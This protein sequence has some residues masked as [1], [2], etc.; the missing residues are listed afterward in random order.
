[1]HNDILSLSIDHTVTSYADI[2]RLADECRA[3]HGFA[4]HMLGHTEPD[5]DEYAITQTCD[6]IK[7]GDVL[8]CGLT[9]A[10]LDRAWP[11]VVCGPAGAFHALKET[12]NWYDVDMDRQR[13]PLIAPR[14]IALAETFR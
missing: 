5:E 1:M 13:F 14:A 4:V 12:A 7:D 11:T 8:V 10:I 3:A 2:A 9:I 6:A